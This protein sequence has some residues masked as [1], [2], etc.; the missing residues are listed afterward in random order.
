MPRTRFDALA[1]KDP[2]IDWV[3]AAVLE[4]M[5]AKKMTL[6]DLSAAVGISY[7][8]MLVLMRKSPSDWKRQQR[9]SVC[10]ALGIET[11]LAVVGQPN[12]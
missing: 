4:R 10:R 2:P 11:V 12:L 9:E 6:K 5:D 3:K 1:R 8:N 7:P